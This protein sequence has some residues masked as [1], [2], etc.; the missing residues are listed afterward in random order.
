MIKR[1]FLIVPL[2]VALAVGVALIE[3]KHTAR[4]STPDQNDWISVHKNEIDTFVAA[5]DCDALWS[6]LWPEAK[7]ENLQARYMLMQFVYPP[8]KKMRMELP[9][10]P[11]SP[12]DTARDAM[13]LGVHSL[14]MENAEK[15]E[16]ENLNWRRAVLQKTIKEEDYPEFHK[17]YAAEKSSAC[18]KL[19]LDKQIVPPFDVFAQEIDRYANRSAKPTCLYGEDAQLD[20]GN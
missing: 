1:V 5:K 16:A 14:G 19:A 6:L 7:N 18:L 12:I 3:A 2:C 8:P 11:D 4:S 13:I 10:H 17:C 20:L 15:Y 9:G